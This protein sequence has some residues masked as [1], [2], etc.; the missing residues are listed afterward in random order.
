METSKLPLFDPEQPYFHISKKY[1]ENSGLRNDKDI[2][3]YSRQMVKDQFKFLNDVV[4]NSKFGWIL[5]CPGT[6]K[7]TTT[8]SILPYFHKKGWTTTWFHL[9]RNEPPACVQL[10]N[11][12]KFTMNLSHYEDLEEIIVALDSEEKNIVLID[13]FTLEEDHKKVLSFCTYWLK[14]NKT[15][16]RIVIISSMSVRRKKNMDHDFELNVEEFFVDSWKIEEYLIAIQDEEFFNSVQ[17]NLDANI[18]LDS[19]KIRDDELIQSKY[20]F[21]GGSSR[22]MFAYP[23]KKVIESLNESIECV[24][25]IIPYIETTIG[26][27]SH[28]VINRLFNIFKTETKKIKSIVSPYASSQIGIIKGPLIAKKLYESLRKDMNPSMDGWM[29]EIWFFAC[30]RNGGI[31]LFDKSNHEEDWETTFLCNFDPKK[32]PNPQTPTWLKPEKFNQGGYDAVYVDKP[33]KTVK[34]VQITRG[35]EHSLKINYFYDLMLK[36]A[37]FFE[38]KTLEIY[39]IVPLKKLMTFESPNNKITGQCLLKQFGWIKGN[40]KGQVKICGIETIE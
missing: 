10:K 39:F 22:L 2:I 34:F 37:E 25:D 3:L 12:F 14:K 9:Y 38:T 35:D 24:G 13:G 20:Y 23:T 4:E 17:E 7:S 36:F 27:T 19:L 18:S 1:L 15:L 28:D 8:Y 5:G 16:N 40:E 26:D 6:G 11:G 30:L 31:K 29:L 33:N 32:P 21:A